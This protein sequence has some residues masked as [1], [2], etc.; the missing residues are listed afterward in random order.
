MGGVSDPARWRDRAPGQQGQD[1]VEGEGWK[2]EDG[3][4]PGWL[5][6]ALPA[7]RTEESVSS[8]CCVCDGQQPVGRLGSCSAGPC[9][10]LK[11]ATAIP[12]GVQRPRGPED[13]GQ[14]Q[15]KTLNLRL[16]VLG[17]FFTP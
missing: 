15:S 7:C 11:G 14:G 6:S 4:F 16:L 3:A 1:G 13:E 12:L 9:H 8:M 10:S 17:A 5:G 2:Q